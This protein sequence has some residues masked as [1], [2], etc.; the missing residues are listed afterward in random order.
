[1][2]ICAPIQRYVVDLCVLGVGEPYLL[3]E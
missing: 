2:T 3:L 1:V